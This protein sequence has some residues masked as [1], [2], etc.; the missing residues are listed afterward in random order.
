M[1]Q[2]NCDACQKFEMPHACRGAFGWLLQRSG[3]VNYKDYKYFIFINSSVRGPYLP[4]Y[5]DSSTWT[6][7]FTSQFTDTIKLVGSSINCE[8][9]HWKG[10][11]KG[12]TRH[13]AHVQSYAIATDRYVLQ[14]PSKS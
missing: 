7:A 12:K 14:P 10:D 5:I 11:T 9:T 8:K 4:A 2:Y 3:E 6:Q 1:M 13:N